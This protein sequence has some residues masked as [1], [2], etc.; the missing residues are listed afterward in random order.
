MKHVQGQ[1]RGWGK[2]NHRQV[3]NVAKDPSEAQNIIVERPD[4]Y[5]RLT[6]ILNRYRRDASSKGFDPADYPE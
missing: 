3:Y 4:I 2:E 1:Y 5:D 6:E